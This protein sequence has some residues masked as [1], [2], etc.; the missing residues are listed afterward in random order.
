MASVKRGFTVAGNGFLL[1]EKKKVLRS[2]KYTICLDNTRKLTAHDV[3]V[4]FKDEKDCVVGDITSEDG[5]TYIEMIRAD[6]V[7]Q[8]E[9][10]NQLESVAN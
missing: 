8:E 7:V 2:G 5:Y 1:E 10:E 3:K 6:L 9:E 4:W